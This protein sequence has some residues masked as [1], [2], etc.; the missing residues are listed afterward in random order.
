M[1]AILVTGST[2]TVGALVVAELLGRD[3]QVRAAVRQ[4]GRERG[5][6]AAVSEIRFDFEDPSTFEAALTGVS[7]VFLMRP[8]Q[9]SDPKKM[10][11]FI[12]AMTTYGIEQVAF[13]SVQGA[14]SNPFV[15]HHGMEQ[16]LKRSG[17]SC[18]FLRPSFFMQNLATTHRADICDRDEVFVPAGRGKTNFID[19]ADVA[20]AIAVVLTTPGHLGK[21]YELTGS[22]AVTYTKVA[23]VLSWACGR[24]IT[25]P[26]PSARE[27]KSRMK[28]SGCDDDF[29]SV[30][31]SIYL[32]AKVGLAAGTT[33][34]LQR[35]IGRSPTT[36][37][38]WAQRNADCFACAA[39]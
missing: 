25:Y 31:G 15:P 27:F 19:A 32:I 14:G 18:T 22:E 12:D 21:A 3:Q 7:S 4:P 8:P 37:R 5:W 38:E 13:L 33:D 30:M 36:L 11:P 23:E 39:E 16:Y 29:V 26:S 2:G 20:E 1:S 34:E 17:L 35:L 10:R 28:A 9:M 6:G 24:R